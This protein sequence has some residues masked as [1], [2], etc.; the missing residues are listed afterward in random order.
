MTKGN[1]DAQQLSAKAS[2]AWAAFARSGNPSTASLPWP[3]YTTDKR[4]TMVWASTPHGED[5]PMGADRQLWE[6][7]TAA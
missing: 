5:D 3:E 6:K 4:A 7:V 1:A 2:A